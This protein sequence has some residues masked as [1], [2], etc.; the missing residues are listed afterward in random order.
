MRREQ[1]TF[2]YLTLS[3]ACW[4]QL[5]EYRL[6]LTSH[7]PSVPICAGRGKLVSDYSKVDISVVV[8][9]TVIDTQQTTMSAEEI[10]NA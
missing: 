6:L 9:V 3:P 5:R 7:L 1:Q 8:S 10:H 2:L 4:T